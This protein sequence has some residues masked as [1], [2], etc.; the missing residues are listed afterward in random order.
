MELNAS[1]MMPP[2]QAGMRIME[3]WHFQATGTEEPGAIWQT[4]VPL[5]SVAIRVLEGT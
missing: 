3:L 4:E 2:R 1:E 5:L